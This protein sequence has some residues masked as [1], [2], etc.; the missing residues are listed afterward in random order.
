MKPFFDLQKPQNDALERSHTLCHLIRKEIDR[1]GG[2]LSFAVFMELAL[3]HPHLGYYN[4][5]TFDLGKKGDFTTAAEISPLYAACF[6]RLALPLFEQLNHFNILEIGAGTGRFAHDLLLELKQAGSKFD[7]YYIYEIS[8]ALRKKQQD[9]LKTTCPELFHHFIW[10]DTLPPSF[11]GL[12]IANEV[13]DALPF[14][15]FSLDD[16]QIKEKCVTWNKDQFSWINTEPTTP[17]LTLKVDELCQLYSLQN[18]YESEINLRLSSFI[19]TLTQALSTGILLFADYGY[20]QREYYHPLR[21]QGTLTCFYQHRHHHDPL[22]LPGLQDITAHVDFTRVACEAVENQCQLAGFT[23]QAAFLL[24]CGLID[25]ASRKEKNLSEIEAFHL[26][27]SIK[28][29]TL[30]S[31]MGERVKMMALSK[32]IEIPLSG[33]GFLDRR[34][35]L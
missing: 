8:T 29:L 32:N 16:N 15:R 3:Y 2:Q 31:E 19:S 13:L 33:F 22:I 34:R 5:E 27:Q 23:T 6:A 20:G 21:S 25:I 26:H 14:H 7:H 10:L 17:E 4:A 9:F 28:S 24:D 18:G 12:M 35:D 1:Q 30:P 11:S